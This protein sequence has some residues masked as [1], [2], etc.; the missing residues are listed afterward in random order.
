MAL[1][2][3]KS[4]S[5]V[6]A[7]ASNITF[8]SG[9]LSGLTLLAGEQ[10]EIIWEGVWPENGLESSLVSQVCSLTYSTIQ[11]R[12]HER[13]QDMSVNSFIVVQ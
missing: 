7:K 1:H 6:S 9:A 11:I 8:H 3:F 12:P 5:S 13:N 10:M 2:L 4:C